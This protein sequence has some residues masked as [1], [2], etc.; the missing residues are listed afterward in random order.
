MEP[1]NSMDVEVIA[2]ALAAPEMA[3]WAQQV[4]IISQKLGIPPPQWAAEPK[5]S[6]G[7]PDGGS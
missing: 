6:A 5:P 3:R 2:R 4:L 1:L 7:E